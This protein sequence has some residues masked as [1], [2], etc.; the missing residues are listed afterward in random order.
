MSVFIH[1]CGVKGNSG[2]FSCSCTDKLGERGAAA[3]KYEYDGKER[4]GRNLTGPFQRG[5][6]SCLSLLSF[7]L[8]FS[9]PIENRQNRIENQSFWK[10]QLPLFFSEEYLAPFSTPVFSS[11]AKGETVSQDRVTIGK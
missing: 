11:I 3:P 10:Y 9:P 7:P 6:T 2:P 5:S 8:L 4:F 1:A